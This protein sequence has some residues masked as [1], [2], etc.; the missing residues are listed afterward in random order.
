MNAV[1]AAISASS[2]TESL[3]VVYDIVGV[4][5]F[6]HMSKHF[7][8]R[9]TPDRK[10]VFD[11]NG[12]RNDGMAAL[13]KGATVTS[14]L[15]GLPNTTNCPVDFPCHV[16]VY[17]LQGGTNA[18]AVFAE[19]QRQQASRLYKLRFSKSDGTPGDGLLPRISREDHNTRQLPPEDLKWLSNPASTKTTEYEHLPHSIH[20][21]PEPMSPSPS[22][23]G[24]SQHRPRKRQRQ[25]ISPEHSN[26]EFVQIPHQTQAVNTLSDPIEEGFLEHTPESPIVDSDTKGEPSSQQ[27]AFPIDCRCGMVGNGH[28][29]QPDEETICCDESCQWN[30]RASNLSKTAKF[31]CDSCDIQVPWANTVSKQAHGPK[32]SRRAGKGALVRQGKYWYPVRLIQFDAHQSGW[33]VR[34]WCL[35]KFPGEHPGNTYWLGRWAHACNVPNG[36]DMIEVFQDT[37]Y[38]DNIDCTLSEHI[39]ELQALLQAPQPKAHQHLPVAQYLLQKKQHPDTTGAYPVKFWGD[40]TI[41][42]RAQIA[43]W[44]FNRI[45]GAQHSVHMWLG[46]LPFAHTLT[47]LIAHQQLV[48]LPKFSSNPRFKPEPLN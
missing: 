35:C 31:L 37:P 4:A 36:E 11:Y 20:E 32:A 23:P 46:C 39:P 7:V 16:V 17:Q 26:I 19:H 29:L 43:N 48:G 45:P 8:V 47:L 1:H 3:G 28:T 38:A 2:T 42:Q 40:F 33:L 41:L 21:M 25:Y 12:M 27:S 9:Y 10:K 44:F 5:Y 30:G 18:Q 13:I 15:A 24:P 14:H 34:W 6:G 22:P